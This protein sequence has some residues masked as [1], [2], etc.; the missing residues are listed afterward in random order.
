MSVPTTEEQRQILAPEGRKAPVLDDALLERIIRVDTEQQAMIPVFTEQLSRWKKEN[1]SERE[2]KEIERLEREL[3]R[4]KQVLEDV[5]K[6]AREHQE[7]TIEKVLAK[8]D[9]EVA[10]DF[11]SGKMRRWM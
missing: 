7:F 11:L 8:D 10:L 6:L 1:P 2:R 5:L 4:H 9:A 3:H